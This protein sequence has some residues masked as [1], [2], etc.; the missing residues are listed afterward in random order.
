M[1][2]SQVPVQAFDREHH[3]AL[4]DLRFRALIGG[5][6]WAR[7]QPAIRSRFSKRLL[8]TYQSAAFREHLT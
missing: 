2:T 7:L 5:T 4:G 6:P 8:I 3:A 1:R